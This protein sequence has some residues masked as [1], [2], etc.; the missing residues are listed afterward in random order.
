F[1]LYLNAVRGQ[2][3]LAESPREK[4]SALS[5]VYMLE[6]MN[7]E[8]VDHLVGGD[9]DELLAAAPDARHVSRYLVSLLRDETLEKLAAANP[10][11]R[12]AAYDR[13]L[14]LWSLYSGI[15]YL[16]CPAELPPERHREFLAQL[17][18]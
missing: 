5:F 14:P 18:Q 8:E 10:L 15:N 3:S 9:L 12:D 2:L 13:G 7:R 11:Y 6:I 16:R 4:I 1:P 17:T